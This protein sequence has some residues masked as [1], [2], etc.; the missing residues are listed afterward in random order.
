MLLSSTFIVHLLS[1]LKIVYN[2]FNCISQLYIPLNI[3]QWHWVLARVDIRNIH[4]NFYDSLLNATTNR[5]EFE[6]IWCM[7][8]YVLRDSNVYNTRP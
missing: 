7:M 2:I 5:L 4:V 3:V 8:P 1:Y 6:A